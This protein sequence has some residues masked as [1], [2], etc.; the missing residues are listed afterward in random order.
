ML[1]FDI[2]VKIAHVVG[3]A[4]WGDFDDAVCDGFDELMV[5]RGEQ[6]DALEVDEPVVDCGD[7]FEVEVVGRLVEEKD[8]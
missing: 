6:D 1:R 3:D 5:V 7:G 4:V 8:V 2:F